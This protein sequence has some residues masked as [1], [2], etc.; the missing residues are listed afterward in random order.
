MKLTERYNFGPMFNPPSLADSNGSLGTAYIGNGIGGTNWTGG[1]YDPETHVADAPAANAAVTSL[2]VTEPPKDFSDIRYLRG[3]KGQPFGEA[4]GPGDCCAADSGY[5]TRED[6][7]GPLCQLG[8][9][10]DGTYYVVASGRAN[11]A[12]RGEWNG[13][14]TG[15]TNFIG[16]EAEN[17]GRANDPWPAVQLDAYHRGVAAILREKGRTAASCCGH[18]EYALPSGRK[19]D[20]N[21]EMDQFRQRVAAILGGIDPPNL[22]PAAETGGLA[23]PTLRRGDSGQFVTELQQRLGLSDGQPI[24]GPNTEA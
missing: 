22:I 14:T 2:S 6:L 1:A 4:W 12:G 21:L 16:I 18:R 10:R 23:R 11:H 5:R 9:G 24:F 19:S 15:N 13:I 20:V 17:S 8:L 7:P 3:I